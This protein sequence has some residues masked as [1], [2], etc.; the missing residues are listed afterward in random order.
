MSFSH[1]F[2]SH[3]DY[4]QETIHR[5]YPDG[6]EEKMHRVVNPPL[7]SLPARSSAQYWTR[8]FIDYTKLLIAITVFVAVLL[9]ICYL[10]TG[11]FRI[12]WNTVFGIVSAL[13]VISV[14]KQDR[15]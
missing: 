11:Y 14:W 4:R 3:S 2:R 15:D 6:V 10:A 9:E 5:S 13:L 12:G 7:A 1:R 8:Q